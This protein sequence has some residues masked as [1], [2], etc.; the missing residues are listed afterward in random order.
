MCVITLEETVVTFNTGKQFHLEW[1]KMMGTFD[2]KGFLRNHYF[3]DGRVEK[4]TF[5]TLI[6]K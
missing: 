1:N 6:I 2:V 5:R 3:G 4:L